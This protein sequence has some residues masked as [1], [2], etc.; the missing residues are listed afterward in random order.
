VAL[1]VGLAYAAVSAN[2][3]AGGTWLLDTVGGTFERWGR[4][5]GAGV[6][7]VL[8]AVVVAKVVAAVLPLLALYSLGPTSTRRAVR[9]LAWADGLILTVYGSVLTAAGLAIQTGVVRAASHADHRALA[10][11]A[12][13]WDPWFLAW[14]LLVIVA[15]GSKAM[16]RG[17][18]RNSSIPTPPLVPNMSDP[19]APIC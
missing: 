13:L 3:G 2:W 12:Y 1:V 19:N 16:A 14:G 10:W 11:H 8:W 5:R 7:A 9:R 18:P 15:L 17:V 6:L 4:S